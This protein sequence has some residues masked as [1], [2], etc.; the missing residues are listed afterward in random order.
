MSCMI[1]LQNLNLSSQKIIEG[2]KNTK[3][4][5]NAIYVAKDVVENQTFCL[6]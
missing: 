3:R 6:Y 1:L 5:K 4:A 2:Y